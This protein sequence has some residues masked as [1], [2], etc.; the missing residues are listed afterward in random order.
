MIGGS[1]SVVADG[2][3]PRES[4]PI[5]PDAALRACVMFSCAWARSR[6]LL[7]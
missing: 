2:T 5:L 4:W 6:R 7:A 1:S 3:K